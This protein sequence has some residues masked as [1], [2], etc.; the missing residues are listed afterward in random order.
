MKKQYKLKRKYVVFFTMYF[1]LLTFY[2]TIF[3]FS[4]YVGI[5]GS[6]KNANIA[7]WNVGIKDQTNEI[8]IVAGNDKTN[9]M[10]SVQSSSEVATTYSIILKNLPENINISLDGSDTITPTN[11]E[12]TFLGVGSFNAN[13][14][15]K[16]TTHEI[17]FSV[18]LG[19]ETLTNQ[20]IDVEVV[21]TQKEI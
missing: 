4:K 11:S 9:Y 6:E 8:T 18:P 14:L 5:I 17:S 16:V 1:T 2:L 3:T 19:Y 7:E 10:L 20:K 15:N 13:E 12:V 21:F